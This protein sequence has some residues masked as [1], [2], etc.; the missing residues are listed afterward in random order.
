MYRKEVVSLMET[1]I[2]AT[3]VTQH[4]EFLAHFK[5]LQN[6]IKTMPFSPLLYV[7]GIHQHKFLYCTPVGSYAVCILPT[8]IPI[9]PKI[10]QSLEWS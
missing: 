3:D 2:L 6:D 5:V 10:K 1:L 4:Q 8:S 9:P 7:N